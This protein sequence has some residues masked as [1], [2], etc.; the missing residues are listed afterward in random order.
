MNAH[1]MGRELSIVFL[2]LF[3]CVMACLALAALRSAPD[4]S[5][6]LSKY[7]QPQLASFVPTHHRDYLRLV[8]MLYLPLL[9]LLSGTVIFAVQVCRWLVAH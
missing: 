3:G 6:M 1:S 9:P 5:P 8:V 7:S 2:W 4:G